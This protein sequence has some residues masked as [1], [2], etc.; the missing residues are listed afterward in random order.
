MLN[1]DENEILVNAVEFFFYIML[2]R[3]T[4]K[5]NWL[6]LVP[7]LLLLHLRKMYSDSDMQSSIR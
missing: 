5:V 6:V 3:S 7:V 4:T 2:T 1:I